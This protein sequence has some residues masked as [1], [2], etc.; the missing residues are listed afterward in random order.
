MDKLKGQEQITKIGQYQK[1][2]EESRERLQAR[3]QRREW[4]DA[5]YLKMEIAA[6]AFLAIVIIGDWL[7][8]FF[9]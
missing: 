7:V 9:I 1:R 4:E 5:V 3:Q 6:T 8:R 2:P